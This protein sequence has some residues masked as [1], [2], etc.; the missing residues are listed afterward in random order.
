MA[1][2]K[3]TK[4]LLN[5]KRRIYKKEGKSQKYY[6]ISR[7]CAKAVESDKLCFSEKLF[8]KSVNEKNSKFFYKAVGYF[9]TKEAPKH[10]DVSD[11]YPGTTDQDIGEIIAEFFNKISQ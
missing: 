6:D 1:Q 10:W 9:R 7:T 11:M 8:S 3:R 2:K 4:R 5:K